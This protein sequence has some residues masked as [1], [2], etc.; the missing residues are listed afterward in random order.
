MLKDKLISALVL[1]L[2]EGTKG[3]V[4]YYDASRVVLG[5][6]LIQHGKVLAYASRQLRVHE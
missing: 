1:N 3:F 6:L 2:L 4:V 5:C